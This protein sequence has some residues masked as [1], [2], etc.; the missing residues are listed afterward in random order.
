MNRGTKCRNLVVS[1]VA[2]ILLG[3]VFLMFFVAF[4]SPFTV[5][6]ERAR[7]EKCRRLMRVLLSATNLFDT[8]QEAADQLR[9]FD[10]PWGN[11]FNVIITDVS[12]SE[13]FASAPNG[14]LL[15]WSSGPNG[16]N[17]NC[18][19]DDV[20]FVGK[21]SRLPDEGDGQ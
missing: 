16:I 3:Y 11:K 5:L 21:S 14:G 19:G 20:L 13:R 6:G 8:V 10:D 4:K 1:T 18:G 2:A 15:M 12:A 7:R 9:Q 17:E